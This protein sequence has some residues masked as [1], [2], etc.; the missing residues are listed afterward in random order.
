MNHSPVIRLSQLFS[1]NISCDLFIEWFEFGLCK[2]FV[3][4]AIKTSKNI[5]IYLLINLLLCSLKIEFE[6]SANFGFSLGLEPVCFLNNLRIRNSSKNFE[7]NLQRVIESWI[8]SWLSTMS[9]FS[10]SKI[11]KLNIDNIWFCDFWLK[12]KLAILGHLP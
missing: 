6:R 11:L 9:S 2:R 4:L 7:W 10:S 5:I 1:T 12:T 3:I 8:S